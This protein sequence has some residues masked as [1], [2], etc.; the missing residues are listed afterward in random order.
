MAIKTALAEKFGLEYPVVLTSIGSV[1]GGH[2]AAAVSNAGGLG[3]VG[4]GYGDRDWMR[5]E[6]SLARTEATVPWGVSLTT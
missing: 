6:L 4:G 1:S 2:L 5:E 3:L